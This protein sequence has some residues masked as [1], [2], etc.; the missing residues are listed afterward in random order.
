MPTIG[1]NFTCKFKGDYGIT[2]TKVSYEML[3]GLIYGLVGMAGQYTDTHF[4]GRLQIPSGNE[5]YGNSSDVY[6]KDNGT[7]AT[8]YGMINYLA[9]TYTSTGSNLHI[10]IETY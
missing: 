4:Y 6:D 3:S 8:F 10:T 7:G 5:T 2:D 1:P 9:Q